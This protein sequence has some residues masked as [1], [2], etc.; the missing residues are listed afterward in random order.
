M[1]TFSGARLLTVLVAAVLATGGALVVSSVPAGAGTCGPVDPSI[2]DGDPGSLR[3]LLENTN[4]TGCTTVTLEPGATYVLDDSDIDIWAD[5]VIEGNG[6]TIRQTEPGSRVLDTDF[7]LTLRQVTITGGR[8]DDDAGGV[9]SDNSDETLTVEN[10]TFVDNGT[11]GDGGAFEAEGNAVVIASTFTNNCAES[12]GG[13]VDFSGD[14]NTVVNSTFTG[15]TS[16]HDGAIDLDG[17]ELTTVYSTIVANVVVEDADCG[18][19]AT[20]DE[21]DEVDG[22]DADSSDDVDVAAAGEPA[23][24]SITATNDEALLRSFGTV[25]ALPQGGPNCAD[26]TVEKGPLP[27]TES[28]GYNFSDDASCGFEDPTDQQDAGDP[29]LG[30]LGPNGGPTET[31]VPDA[32]SPLLNAIPIDAC[33]DGDAFAG[34]EVTTDQRGVAR[35]QET[36]CE[37]GSVE[38]EPPPPAP[39]PAAIVLE[40]TFTG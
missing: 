30:A 19:T 33:G 1:S 26:D 20:S 35:P 22:V 6:A 12:T 38:V 28:A 24:I 23:S 37:I 8:S 5:M 29:A 40:P 13:A 27:N 2:P 16:D 39:E 10:S 34:F 11:E 18:V 17:D 36:G 3:N 7:S 14:T 25:I 9:R 21:V 32:T 15:N 4:A 31:M